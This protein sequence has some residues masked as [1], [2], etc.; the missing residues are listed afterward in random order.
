MLLH[1]ANTLMMEFTYKLEIRIF[2]N[3]A[4]LQ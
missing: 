1:D 3:C 2:Y 4:M